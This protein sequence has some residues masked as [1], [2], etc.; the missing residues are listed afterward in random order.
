MDRDRGSE[1]AEVLTRAAVVLLAAAFLAIYL[2][3]LG[4]WLIKDDYAWIAQSTIG[5]PADVL[6]LFAGAPSGFYR[7]L[8]AL[9]FGLDRLAFGLHPLGYALTNLL[10][11]L[12]AAALLLV[13]ARRAGVGAGAAIVAAA[14]WA[15]NPHGINMALLWSSGRTSLLL[16]LFA[17][18]AAAALL[19]GGR[20]SVAAWTLAALWS[21]ETAV[22][23]PAILFVWAAIWPVDAEARPSPDWRAA[24]R[25]TGPAFAALVVYL[26]LRSQSGAMT[27]LTAPSYYRFTFAP[28]HVAANVLQYVDRACTWPA[29]IL[30]LLVLIVGR[31]PRLEPA[32]RRVVL[33]GLVWL[34]LGYAITIF[35]PVRSSLYACFPSVGAMLMAAAVAGAL[36]REARPIVR[37]RLV[38]AGLALPFV[39]WPLYHARNARWVT[40][41]DR[42][43]TVLAG[44]ARETRSLPSGT[45]LIVDDEQQ[46]RVSVD[47]IF[48]TQLPVAVALTTGRTFDLSVRTSDA[49]RRTSDGGVDVGPRTLDPGQRNAVHLTISPGG[50]VAGAAPNGHRRGSNGRVRCVRAPAPLK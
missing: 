25:R 50:E 48:G 16:T 40:P 6:R 34:V 14:L 28:P 9:S 44:I 31:R 5:H 32:E 3:G 7:P 45:P 30:L 23:L 17:L 13:V 43:A 26:I 33:G 24:W 10:L 41:A 29:V 22:L 15:F 11:V 21:K 46:G 4:H 19:R 42:A 8:V 37:P 20:W 49:G 12:S 38:A 2:P 1:P 39:L 35:L 18:G 47:S 36:W 27:P